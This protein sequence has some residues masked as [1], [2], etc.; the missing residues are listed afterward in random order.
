MVLNKDGWQT[1]G[2]GSTVQKQSEELSKKKKKKKRGLRVCKWRKILKKYSIYLK[3]I[4]GAIEREGGVH[5][6][7]FAN[8]AGPIPRDITIYTYSQWRITN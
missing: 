6:G 7:Q 8:L 5:S 1:C 4:P 3:P 2:G